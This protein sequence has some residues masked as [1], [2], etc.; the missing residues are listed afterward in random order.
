MSKYTFSDNLH[1]DEFLGVQ[2]ADFVGR[3][4]KAV[5]PPQM[6]HDVFNATSLGSQCYQPDYIKFPLN[7]QDSE[8]CLN[9]NI[10]VPG[11]VKFLG[12]VLN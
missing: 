11:G 7:Q 2:Y 4:K 12:C 10:Y 9:L 6:I 8:D 5:Y 3:F 1:Y